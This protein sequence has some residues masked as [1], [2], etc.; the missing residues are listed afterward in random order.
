VE[1]AT[2][3]NNFQDPTNIKAI[4]FDFDGT[5]TSTP[6]DKA[7]RRNK[8]RDL[9][10]RGPMLATRLLQLRKAGIVLGII[11]KSTES[12]I[13]GTLERAGLREIFDGPIVPNA[14]GF[15]GKAGFIRELCAV[16]CI[17]EHLDGSH[18]VLLVDDDLSELGLARD[19]GIQTYAA[20]EN[21]GLQEEDFDSIIEG[22]GIGCPDIVVRGFQRSMDSE[23]R[24]GQCT[25]TLPL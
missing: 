1:S 19:A 8:A 24:D 5:L 12:T 14:V 23:M 20:P 15:E 10:E 9:V 6:G 25:T 4:F 11:S 22:L 21:G 18:D 13:T 17:L 2:Y 16:G 3:P 7:I